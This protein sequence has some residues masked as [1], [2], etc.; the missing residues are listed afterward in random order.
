MEPDDDAPQP[1]RPTGP[2]PHA[3]APEDASE[4]SK[5]L[6]RDVSALVATVDQHSAEI[7]ALDITVLLLAFAF[8][9]LAGIVYLHA[10]QL[11]ELA[12]AFPS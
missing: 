5:R 9:A 6:E 2:Q 10:R 4:P 7:D 1:H 12:D 11:S 3:D 8:G